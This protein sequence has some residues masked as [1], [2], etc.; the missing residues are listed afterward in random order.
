MESEVLK[1]VH[2]YLV[3]SFYNHWSSIMIEN[4]FKSHPTVL[5]N[6]GKTKSVDFFINEIPFDLKV[7][8]L[9]KFF[10][11]K[12]REEFGLPKEELKSLKQT[13]KELNIKFINND[14]NLYYS[15]SKRLKDNGTEKALATLN[16]IKDVKLKIINSIKDNPKELAKELYENQ[17]NFRFGAENRLFLVLVDKEDY[18]ASWEL[19]RNIDLLKPEI[20]KYLDGFKNKKIDDLEISFYKE[21][22]PKSYP[23]LYKSLS[24]ILIIEK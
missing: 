24:D 2:D 1:T 13:A 18:S 23:N 22:N 3:C 5:S 10:V 19:R 14:V 6:I 16:E 20:F 11:E 9:P 4:I 21:G 8:Y 7:T 17:S 15:L 12:K